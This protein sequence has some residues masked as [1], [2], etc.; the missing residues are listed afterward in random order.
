MVFSIDKAIESGSAAA[1]LPEV[2]R[3][4]TGGV[5]IRDVVYQKSDGTV[6]RADASSITTAETA[7]GLVIAIDD[8]GAGE[9][10]VRLHGDMDGFTGLTVGGLY[11]LA[12]SPGQIVRVDDT[13]NPN[14]PGPGHA[15]REV[16]NAVSTTKL[17]IEPGRDFEVL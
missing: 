9:C 11:V 5:Q 15:L 12:S 6:D 13:G 4:Y 2:I 14:Y 17:F 16:G 1:G 7:I 3:N 10:R 8:P